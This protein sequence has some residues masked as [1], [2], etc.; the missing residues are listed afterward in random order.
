MVSTG[1]VDGLAACAGAPLVKVS[2]G[3]SN[4]AG[5][6][7]WRELVKLH[8]RAVWSPRATGAW[9]AMLNS[10][11]ML[12][13]LAI[14]RPRLI[15]K[16]YR[17]Y[18]TNTLSF[19]ER[20]MLLQS[21]YDFIGRK[22]LS[23]LVLKAGRQAVELARVTTK[24]DTIYRIALRAVEPMEREGELAMQLLRGE[25]LVYTAAFSFFRSGGGMVLG[26]GCMQG[27]KGDCGLGL[28]KEAT[29]DMHG[30]RPKNLMVKLLSALGHD[31]GCSA[32]R[33]VGNGNR[34]VNR[35]RR[36][37]RVHA[38]Y[39]TLWRECGALLRADGDFHLDC[40][41][42]RPPDLQD[43]PSSKRSA[44]RK[45]HEILESIVGAAL[46]TFS[47]PPAIGPSSAAD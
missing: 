47:R 17:P 14:A 2:T 5:L 37:G 22:G 21:H 9:L 34:A 31:L 43:I 44:A 32:L 13:A 30:L 6:S 24:S 15:G 20:L 46:N 8:L 16:I 39:D 27:P 28:I 36:D 26:V 45:R 42:P 10:Q 33:L 41:V 38:D 7:R 23:E 35:A 11:P 12:R 19:S 3:A 40:D 29:R 4:Y 18:L 25:T 1:D